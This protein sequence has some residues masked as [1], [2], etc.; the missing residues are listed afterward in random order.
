MTK[1]EIF[2]E[3]AAA[4]LAKIS[5]AYGS[6]DATDAA[7][8]PR[9]WSSFPGTENMFCRNRS[10]A[11][12]EPKTKKSRPGREPFYSMEAEYMIQQEQERR[13]RLHMIHSRKAIVNEAVIALGRKMGHRFPGAAE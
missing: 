4:Y 12:S 8:A 1:G 10:F 6:P 5:L 11:M 13:V 2:E 9:N 7:P 3:T